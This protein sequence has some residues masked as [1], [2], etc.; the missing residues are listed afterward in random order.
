MKEYLATAKQVR[1]F[2][3]HLTELK[4]SIKFP[5]SLEIEDDILYKV[6][7]GDGK[8]VAVFSKNTYDI[9]QEL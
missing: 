8:P 7:D 4:K 2:L 5:M 1:D 3:N 9:F 6:F